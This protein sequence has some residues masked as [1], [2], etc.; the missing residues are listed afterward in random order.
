MHLTRKRWP[1][2][3][4]TLSL[5][6]LAGCGT[7]DPVADNACLQITQTGWRARRVASRSDPHPR[8]T[9]FGHDSSMAVPPKGDG[10]QT[11]WPW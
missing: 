11:A 2:A 5:I 8:P 7:S 3:A 10:T 9:A 1:L 6:A 4:L